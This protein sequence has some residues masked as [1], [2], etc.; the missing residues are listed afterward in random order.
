MKILSEL[1]G[2]FRL[3]YQILFKQY[4]FKC[5]FCNQTIYLNQKKCDRCNSKIGW[6]K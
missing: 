5:P 6:E 2:I 3:G 1:K 4:V